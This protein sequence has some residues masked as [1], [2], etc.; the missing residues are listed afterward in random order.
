MNNQSPIITKTAKPMT[1]PDAIKAV[2]GGSKI[3]RL[4]WGNIDEYGFVKDEKLS[5]H[6]KG[7][8]HTWIVS[9]GDMKNNDWVV[10]SEAN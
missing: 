10:I 9:A 3:T 2:I 4:E 8:D 6:T 5:I 7:K 1:F